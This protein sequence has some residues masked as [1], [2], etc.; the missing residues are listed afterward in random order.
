MVKLGKREGDRMARRWGVVSFSREGEDAT[1]DQSC[2]RINAIF[3][4]HYTEYKSAVTTGGDCFADG[5]CEF[6]ISAVPK[7][8]KATPDTYTTKVSKNNDGGVTTDGIKFDKQ[9]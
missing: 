9:D 3:L 6:T 7:D 8:P 2:W 4:Q 5:Q 1:V